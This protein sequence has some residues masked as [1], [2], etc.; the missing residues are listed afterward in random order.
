VIN[1]HGSSRKREGV[2]GDENIF[3]IK[4][5][6]TITFFIKHNDDRP[7]IVKY[8][9]IYGSRE[10]KFKW[11][12]NRFLSQIEFQ[13]VLP[14]SPH[15]LFIPLKTSVEYQLFPSIIDI[16]EKYSVGI[17]TAR[18]KFTIDFDKEAL[19]DRLD[20]F[21]K[22]SESD[23]RELFS[24][25]E[26][27]EDWKVTLA[28]EDVRSSKLS[29]QKFVRITYRPFDVRF[30]YY[31]G[32]SKGLICRPRKDIMENMLNENEAIVTTR[33]SKP[34]PWRDVFAADNMTDIALLS[35]NT[36]RSS[37]HFPLYI[38]EEGRRLSNIKTEIIENLSEKYGQKI[39]PETL[40]DYI[41]GLLNS[42]KYRNKYEKE[43]Q[44]DFPRIWFPEAHDVFQ[45]ISNLG[46]KLIDLHTKKTKISG[47]LGYTVAGDNI[48]RKIEY[49][50]GT[51]CINETQCFVGCSQEI[52]DFTI[53]SYKV[54]EKWLKSRKGR[55]LTSADVEMF[56][57]I[58]SIIKATLQIQETLDSFI[59][60]L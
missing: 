9:E 1:L 60:F 33:G 40:F 55:S 14:Q 4:Q 58:A 51:I 35:A 32:K 59:G 49:V 44:R 19:I 20:K 43:L 10:E 37:Y 11:L 7:R 50:D 48:I 22:L 21:I 12:N 13:D 54:L 39:S 42:P 52:W 29:D 30:T 24:L 28:Q 53:G 23:A 57:K 41:Y 27:A 46:R 6:V 8:S 18:D 56:S 36:S 34:E 15:Y 38:Y 45:K 16:F 25:G 26:D 5:G 3:D 47:M 17:A 2:T 31:T